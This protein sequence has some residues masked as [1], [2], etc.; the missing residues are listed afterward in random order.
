VAPVFYDTEVCLER[1]FLR[2]SVGALSGTRY[3]ALGVL[4][5]VSGPEAPG[6]I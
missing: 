5:T 3:E 2:N 1:R 4:E 6:M